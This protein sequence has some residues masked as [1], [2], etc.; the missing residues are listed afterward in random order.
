M[1]K[2]QIYFAFLKTVKEVSPT[3]QSW[4]LII[5]IASAIIQLHK[6]ALHNPKVAQFTIHEKT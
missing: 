5:C 4:I 1:E 6:F 3:H 2:L